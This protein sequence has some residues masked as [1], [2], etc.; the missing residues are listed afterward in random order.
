[1]RRRITTYVAAVVAISCAG[2]VACMTGDHPLAPQASSDASAKNTDRG[3]PPRTSGWRPHR[4]RTSSATATAVLYTGSAMIGAARRPCRLW[5]ARAEC[6]AGGAARADPDH[7]PDSPGD[8]IA[9][10]FQPQGLHFLL[11]ATLQLSYAQCQPQP[12]GNLSIVYVNDLLDKL[13]GLIES[14]LDPAQ[15]KVIGLVTHFSLYA[16]AE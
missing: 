11:P 4:S 13:L 15:H 3:R 14:I 1:M 10:Q 12:K 9:V 7:G 2:L 16:V 6:A 8:T 5:A